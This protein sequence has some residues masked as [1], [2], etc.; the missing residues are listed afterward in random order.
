MKATVIFDIDLP[1]G[2]GNLFDLFSGNDLGTYL[3]GMFRSMGTEQD[4]KF[5]VD[6]IR[7]VKTEDLL[8][9]IQAEHAQ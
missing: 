4:L 5:S 1:D 8:E 2:P 3:M 9:T 6:N 7:A